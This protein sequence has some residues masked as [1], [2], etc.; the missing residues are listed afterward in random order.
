MNRWKPT[1]PVSV[2]PG[3]AHTFT[4]KV[5][6]FDRNL[7]FHYPSAKDSR[8]AKGLKQASGL[9]AQVTGTGSNKR[10]MFADQVAVQFTFKAHG[11]DLGKV[12]LRFEKI[13]REAAS[14]TGLAD[15][16]I[17]IYYKDM[18]QPRP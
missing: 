5:L 9:E 14:F 7:I 15:K 6:R 16:A 1:K 8:L 13:K 17:E 11:P 4:D 2:E 18:G 12:K 10:Y 3:L